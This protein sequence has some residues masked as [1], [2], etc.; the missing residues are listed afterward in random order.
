MV[1]EKRLTVRWTDKANQ[2]FEDIC[3]N[4]KQHSPSAALRVRSE[5]FKSIKSLPLHPEKYQIDEYYPHNPRTIRRFFRWSYR[6]IYE[7]NE[8]TIDI[9]NVIQTSQDTDKIK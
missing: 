5:I 1:A 9:L 6:I 3:K 8:E 7:I 2:S 4:I